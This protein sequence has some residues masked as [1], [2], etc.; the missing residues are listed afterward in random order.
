MSRFHRVILAG[1]LT[2]AFHPTAKAIAIYDVEAS[3]SFTVISTGGMVITAEPTIVPGGNNST[4]TTGTGVASLDTDG[5]SPVG[6]GPVALG[7][8]DSVTQISEL[9]GSADAPGGTSAASILNSMLIVL[10]NTSL[11][12]SAE[13]EFLF[14]YTWDASISRTSADLEAAIANPFF[15]LSGFAP[16]GAETLEVDSGGGRIPL[17]EFLVDN[18]ID[19]TP[20]EADLSDSTMGSLSVSVFVTVLADRTDSFEVI[21][22]A[23]GNAIHA[24]PAP[25]VASLMLL[26]FAAG[27][28]RRRSVRS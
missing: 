1:L 15:H 25:A 6:A 21:N 19:L 12:T 22:D 13:A 7:V 11:T 2:A 5:Q 10:T 27:A 8:G 28:W 20:S 9:S 26:G 24:A 23:T 3:S 17:A 18:T 4:S 14:T 16:S